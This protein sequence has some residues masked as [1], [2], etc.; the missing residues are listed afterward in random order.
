MAKRKGK[1][2]VERLNFAV[3]RANEGR[4]IGPFTLK[5]HFILRKEMHCICLLSSYQ[6][7]TLTPNCTIHTHKK[8]TILFKIKIQYFLKIVFKKIYFIT[9]RLYY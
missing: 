4:L 2:V 7:L 1:R 3:E 5:K 8:K 9:I 6:Y